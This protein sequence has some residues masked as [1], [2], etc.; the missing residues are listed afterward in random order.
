MPYL[1][2]GKT[3]KRKWR[4]R[5]ETEPRSIKSPERKKKKKFHKGSKKD[6]MENVFSQLNVLWGKFPNLL[7]TNFFFQF[8]TKMIFFQFASSPPP[9]PVSRVH[10]REK[11][12]KEE[13]SPKVGGNC[14]ARRSSWKISC[15]R[16]SQQD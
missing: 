3:F 5:K 1:Y 14:A 4:K 11:R 2:Y 6:V 10:F 9:L 12:R 16:K 13:V 7:L 8:S 15:K